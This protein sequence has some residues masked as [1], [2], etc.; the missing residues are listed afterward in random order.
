MRTLLPDEL[1]QIQGF[2]ADFKL[3]GN[4][5]DQVVQVGNAV[6]PPMIQAVANQLKTLLEEPAPKLKRKVRKPVVRETK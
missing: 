1:K 6:P 4:K 2:P 3:S 5:K